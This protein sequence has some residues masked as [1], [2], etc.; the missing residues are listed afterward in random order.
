MSWDDLRPETR[1]IAE[2]TLTEKQLRALQGHLAGA[3]LSQIALDLGGVSRATAW[4]HIEAALRN[5]QHALR[6]DPA[7]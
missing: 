6:K 5:L 2:R 7:A 3:T 1:A 4:G